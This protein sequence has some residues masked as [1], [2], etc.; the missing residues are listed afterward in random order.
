MIAGI[1]HIEFNRLD[2]DDIERIIRASN[3]KRELAI[4]DNFTALHKAAISIAALLSGKN[5]IYNDNG[6]YIRITEKTLDEK[7]RDAQRTLDSI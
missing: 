5:E 2:L 1:S 6:A 3:K 4:N 7:L